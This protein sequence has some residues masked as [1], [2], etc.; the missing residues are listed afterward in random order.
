MT[1]TRHGRLGRLGIA[2]SAALMALTTMAVVAMP[3]SARDV[4]RHARGVCT[5]TS[6]WELELE[7]EHGR[8][9]VNVE[10]DTRRVGR[11]WEVKVWHNG[12]R[13][14]SVLRRTDRDGDVE[15][16]RVRP[17]R[18]G[19]DTFHFRAVDQVNGEVCRGTLSI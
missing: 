12:T 3:A 13:F 4:E 19:R 2:G 7:K 10:V 1:T 18:R 16:E 17:D 15:L 6:D 5:G 11:T 14:A 8:I 9:E